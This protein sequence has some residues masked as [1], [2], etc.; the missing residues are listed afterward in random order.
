MHAWLRPLVDAQRGSGA[1][2]HVLA[3]PLRRLVGV[4]ADGVD[5]A[6]EA[7]A[8]AA[9]GG[10]GLKRVCAAAASKEERCKGGYCAYCMRR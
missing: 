8:L 7:D 2:L 10:R 1:G 4:A 6:G 3:E 9:R 5:A